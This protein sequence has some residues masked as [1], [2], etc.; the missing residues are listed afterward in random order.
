MPMANTTRWWVATVAVSTALTA[1]SSSTSDFRVAHPGKVDLSTKAGTALTITP[2]RML[3]A[4][5]GLTPVAFG[6]PA[7][8]KIAYAANGAMTY[9]P[10]AGFTGTDELTVTVSRA[11]KTYAENQLPLVTMGGVAIKASAHG[12]GIAAVPG[13]SDEIYGLTD[14]GPNVGGRTPN[15]KVLPVPDFQPHIAKLKLADGVATVERTIALRGPDGSPLVG[16]VDRQANTGESAVDLNGTPLPPSDYGVDPEGLV[17]TL[18]GNFWVSDEYGPYLIHFDANGKELERLSP[19]DRTLPQ[20]LS[21]R[22]PNRGMEGLT[23]SPDGTMLAGIM[24]SALQTPG[25]QGPAKFVPL[26][27]IVT[28]NVVDPQIVHEYLYPLANPQETDVAISEITALSATT[29]LVV[30][31]DSKTAPNAN[32][33]IY[34]VDI[35]GATDVGPRSTV[36]GASYQPD[37][38]GLLINGVPIETAIGVST[39]TDAVAKLRAAGITVAVKTLKLDLEA[40]LRTLSANGDFYGH[41]KI[42]GLITP[43]GGKT[44]VIANDSDFGLAGLASATP[45]MRLQPKILPNGTQDNGEFLV[46]DTTGLPPK[47]ETVTVRMK[48]G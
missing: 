37:A 1:C 36:P 8:G 27:R 12:S 29:F 17:A 16:L 42:E 21:L 15:E 34:A 6:K 26:A 24:Q 5:G 11:V 30:E 46:V 45:P 7:H 48:V 10:D 14:R 9:T 23:I 43:D 3:A 13:V 22:S 32:K 44:L 4:T 31:R 35:A 41:D 18:D 40:L 38:G 47:T 33:K 25:L 28:V 2:D 19:S 20:E 39:D